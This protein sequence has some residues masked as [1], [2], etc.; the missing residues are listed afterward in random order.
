VELISIG[1]DIMDK[2][3]Q[4]KNLSVKL[5]DKYV[6]RNLNME[7]YRGEIVALVGESG[8]GK[9]TLAKSIMGFLKIDDGQ[10]FLKNKRI[11]KLNDK[12]Y[13]KLR[14][15]EIAMVFQNSMNAFNPT[16]KVGPQV[17][18][19]IIIHEPKKK[20]SAWKKIY[21]AFENLNLDKKR[22][23]NSYPHELS[24]G[25]KQRA[26]F[27]MGTICEPELLIL[28]EITTSIDSINTESILKNIEEN[29]NKKAILLITHNMKLA[30]NIADRVAVIKNGVIVE[31]GKSILDNPLHPYTKLLIS[32]ELKSSCERKKITIPTYKKTKIISA[33]CPFAPNCLDAMKIC[34]EEVGYEVNLKDRILRCWQYHPEVLRRNS[35]D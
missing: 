34:I 6:V 19:P 7:I 9:S 31:E 14:G 26:A 21:K 17:R 27:A 22:T 29:K 18:E 32:S 8:S 25:M 2:I 24:G 5:G 35:G 20:Q 13:S 33:G 30:R 16:I 15:K 23:Y 12:N 28:D 1:G 11:D 10:I 3:L 4:I